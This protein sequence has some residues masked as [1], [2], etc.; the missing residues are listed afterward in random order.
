VRSA[1]GRLAVALSVALVGCPSTKPVTAAGTATFC[2]AII[3]STE[4]MLDSSYAPS[5]GLRFSIQSTVDAYPSLAFNAA[6]P[7]T[8]LLAI[9]YDDTNGTAAGTTVQEAATGGI[10]WTQVS[11]QGTQTGSFSLAL[12]DAGEA[13]SIDGGTLW[14]APQGSLTVTLVPLGTLTDAGVKVFV[15]F[16][17][18]TTASCI[19][20]DGGPA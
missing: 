6:L 11:A 5:A 1:V 16:N 15:L 10:T 18:A 17:P 13:L 20:A 8:Q 7:G 4:V 9:T 12:T 2:Q 14:P 19:L 3:G